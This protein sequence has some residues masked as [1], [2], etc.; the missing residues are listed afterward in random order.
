MIRSKEIIRS[1]DQL[2]Q[3][4]GKKQGSIITESNWK[5]ADESRK[6]TAQ[7]VT[8]KQPLIRALNKDVNKNQQEEVLTQKKPQVM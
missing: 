2:L 3:A 6:P 8:I 1:V 5:P 4:S 7:S